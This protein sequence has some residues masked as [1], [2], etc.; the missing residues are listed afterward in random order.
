MGAQLDHA[1]TLAAQ[2]MRMK[3]KATT[4]QTIS[5]TN[6]LWPSVLSN[7]GNAKANPTTKLIT[8][9]TDAIHHFSSLLDQ[10]RQRV[11]NLLGSNGKRG[12]K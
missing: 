3:T 2:N 6:V 11:A 4:W 7:L 9:R 12:R 8:P 5:L 10:F 1:P